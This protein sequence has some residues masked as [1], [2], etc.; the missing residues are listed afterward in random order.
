MS[1]VSPTRSDIF[2]AGYHYP[3]RE[4]I[5]YPTCVGINEPLSLTEPFFQ[6]NAIALYERKRAMLRIP[7]FHDR[8]TADPA[9]LPYPDPLCA[10]KSAR[11]GGITT[12]E[13]EILRRAALTK[14]TLAAEATISRQ[15][16]GQHTQQPQQYASRPDIAQASPSVSADNKFGKALLAA[17]AARK[18]A[19]VKPVAKRKL[20]E[21][22]PTPSSSYSRKVK[23]AKKDR[24]GGK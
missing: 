2:V 6:V 16:G 8:D 13:T 18:Q 5:I 19:P 7:V 11:R 24:R 15:H 17:Q 20:G 23:A 1:Q 22:E 9:M 12:I 3:S 14:V 4:P 21:M 10:P